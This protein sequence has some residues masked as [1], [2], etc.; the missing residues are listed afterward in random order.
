MVE[1]GRKCLFD[2]SLTFFAQDLYDKHEYEEAMKLSK[3]FEEVY[4]DHPGKCHS[5]VIELFELE[6]ASLILFCLFVESQAFMC[7]LKNV[8]E[9][10]EEA[11]KA[12]KGVLFKNMKNFTV[13]QLYGLLKKTNK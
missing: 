7:V 3:Y 8:L 2:C 5:R 13:W 9:S 6:N 10:K 11:E 12:M 1:D 4:P